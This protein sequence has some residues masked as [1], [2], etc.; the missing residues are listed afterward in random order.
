MSEG[1]REEAL[2]LVSG[3]LKSGALHISD[4]AIS[5]AAA[6]EDSCVSSN[7]V[8]AGLELAT[9]NLAMVATATEQTSAT[10][11]EIAGNAEQ[12]CVISDEASRQADGVTAMMRI[13]GAAAIR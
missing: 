6:A 3:E 12:V 5:V 2:A 4:R 9:A 8:A 1:K 11:L 10:I 7:S 13:L